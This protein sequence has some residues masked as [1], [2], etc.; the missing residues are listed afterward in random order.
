MAD[1]N[2]CQKCGACCAAYRVSFYAGET[3]EFPGGIVPNGL[4]EQ[5]NS[6]M[7]CMRGTEQHPVRCVALRGTIGE[8][9]GCSIYEF[10]P[11]P[12]RE[13]S[14]YSLLGQGDESCAEARRRHGLPPLENL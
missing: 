14:P 8:S 7:A 4:V 6:V 5:I 12:C 9:V 13:F 1:L 2:P 11:S 10:R 3:D